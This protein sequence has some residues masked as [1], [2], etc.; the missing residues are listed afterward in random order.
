M[1]FTQ[2]TTKNFSL[3]H[4]HWLPVRWRVQFKLCCLMHSIFYGKYPWYLDNIMSH[5]DCGRPRRGLRPSSSSD[6]SLPRLRTKFGE[7]AFAYAGPSGLY[8]KIYVLL[9]ILD[10]S[11]NDLKHTFTVCSL[12]SVDDVNDRVMHLCLIMVIDALYILR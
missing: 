4:L 3:L 10:C 9:L 8:R 11:E 7:R 6:F 2:A 1:V 12:M 5:V